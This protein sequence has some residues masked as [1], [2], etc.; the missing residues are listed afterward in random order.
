M[1]VGWLRIG[2]NYIYCHNL[3]SFDS[4]LLLKDLNKHCE[5]I[6]ILMDKQNKFISIDV[7]DKTRFRDSLRILLASLDSL[8][9]MFDVEIKKGYLDHENVTP[10]LIFTSDFKK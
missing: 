2:V 6:N 10:K 3:G 1:G 9:K 7:K 5:D 8:S 4:Y